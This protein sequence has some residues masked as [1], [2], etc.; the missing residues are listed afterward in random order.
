MVFEKMF[1][2]QHILYMLISGALTVFLILVF[3]KRIKSEKGKNLILKTVAVLTV[4]IHYSALLVEYLSEGG[5]AET[6]NTYILPMYPCNVIMWLFLILA[7][8]E[9]KRGVVFRVLS[10]FCFLVGSVCMVVGIVFNYNFDS[11]PT[12]LDYEVLKGLLSHSVLLVGCLYLYFGRYVKLGIFNSVSMLFGFLIFVACG[13]T[14]NLLF[15]AFDISVIDGFYLIEVP[16]IGISSVPLGLALVLVVFGIYALIELRLPESERW[17][18]KIKAIIGK[19][20][21]E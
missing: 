20:K 13:A 7:F 15:S 9:N 3:V 14:V 10:E 17:Y 1:N 11:N 4:L 6:E 21:K 5:N 18:S 2:L 16:G 12:L 8:L 19:N